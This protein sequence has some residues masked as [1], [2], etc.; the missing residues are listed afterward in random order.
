M[1]WLRFVVHRIVLAALVVAAGLGVLVASAGEARADGDGDW[2]LYDGGL[3]LGPADFTN[4]VPLELTIDF[5]TNASPPVHWADARM[6]IDFCTHQA[7]RPAWISDAL[8]RD[9]VEEGAAM[10]NRAGAAVGI[11][12]AGDCTS[13]TRWQDGNSVNEIGWD[14]ER[15]VVNAPAAAVA[16]GAWSSLTRQFAEVNIVLHRNLNV[17]EVCFRSVIAHELGHALG[18]GHS[19]D[20][21]DLMYASFNAADPSTCPTEATARERAWLID[22]YGSNEPPVVEAPST[23]TAAPGA[24]TTVTVEA[25]KTDGSALTF[26]WTQEAGPTVTLQKSAASIT[27][28]APETVGTE[29]R[30]RVD[31]YDRYMA[32]ASA[33]VAVTV[34]SVAS[35]PSGTPSLQ[36]IGAGEQAQTALEW[37]ALTG[38]TS[39]RFCTTP[40]GGG[41]ESCTTQ[42]SPAASVTWGTE[43]TTAGSPGDTRVIATGTR[44]TTMLACNSSGCS[45]AG[46]GPH[47]GGLR[48][49]AWEMDYDVFAMSFDVPSAGVRFTIVGVVNLE[50]PARRFTLYSGTAQDPTARRIMGC[51]QVPAGG[52]CIGLLAPGDGG[53][54]SLATITSERSGTPTVEHRVRI[55]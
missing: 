2:W 38:A 36:L 19:D 47:I 13:G 50:G 18:F 14:D 20:P 39:Y 15:N 45:R 28:V 3:Q 22:L 46:V 1:D 25:H 26:D 53:H 21:R 44:E 42:P 9:A 31:V 8:F 54:T 49:A 12:Y 4:G 6:P 24:T 11:R 5:F 16:M 23:K 35:A 10:W 27:F 40:T 52:T 48:W 43:L 37:N 29:L 34:A 41:T 17:P 51:G 30:F 32:T 33:T 7:N 55:R